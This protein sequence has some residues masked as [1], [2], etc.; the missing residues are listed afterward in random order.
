MLLFSR[1]LFLI[2][3]QRRVHSICV[4]N[5]IKQSKPRQTRYDM[6]YIYDRY[7]IRTH[8]YMFLFSVKKRVFELSRVWPWRWSRGG[9]T[10]MVF[11]GPVFREYDIVAMSEWKKKCVGLHRTWVSRRTVFLV[12]WMNSHNFMRFCYIVTMNI[13]VSALLDEIW[14]NSKSGLNLHYTTIQNSKQRNPFNKHIK[15]ESRYFRPFVIPTRRVQ[16]TRIDN[17]GDKVPLIFL[18]AKSIF[19]K[20][21]NIVSLVSGK[22]ADGGDFKRKK[23]IDKR[24]HVNMFK[25]TKST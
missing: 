25:T 13:I 17:T 22:D 5:M 7:Y 4:W 15:Y 8:V 11:I 23:W 24:K 2:N 14:L 6:T 9:T 1:F 18:W 21:Q 20:I 12:V 10:Y 16:I 19:F 3:F